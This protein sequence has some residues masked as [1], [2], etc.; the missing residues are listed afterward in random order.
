MER[1]HGVLNNALQFP[2]TK[3]VINRLPWSKVAWKH[4]PLAT[5]LIDIEDG[6]HDVTK[7]MFTLSFLRIN[8]FFD[9]LPLFI[10][11]VS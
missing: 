11:K 8:D 6:V 2:F 9:N 10:S 4:S 3:V 7:L 5:G 1:I